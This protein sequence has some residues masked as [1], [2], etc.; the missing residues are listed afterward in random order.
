MKIPISINDLERY[1]FCAVISITWFISTFLIYMNIKEYYDDE[2]VALLSAIV[3][4]LIAFI[5]CV[6]YCSVF[7]Y[8]YNT[9]NSAINKVGTD[10]SW[11]LFEYIEIINIFNNSYDSYD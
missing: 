11:D 6:L 7:I 5:V 4:P 3:T 1:V 8:R 9:I 2:Y 10:E